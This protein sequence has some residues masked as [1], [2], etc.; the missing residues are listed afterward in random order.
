[1]AALRP[2]PSRGALGLHDPRLTFDPDRER[3]L[4]YL[5]EFVPSDADQARARVQIMRW[6]LAKQHPFE[7]RQ[8]DGHVTASALVIDAAGERALLTHHA[9]LDRWLQFGGHADGDAN[10]AGVALRESIEESGIDDLVIEPRV[11]DVDVHTIPAR[12]DEA[13][14]LHLDVRFLVW[15]PEG[16]KPV[17]S[18]ES[19]ALAWVAADA[20]GG[21]ALDPSVVRLFELARSR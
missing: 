16:A 5:R 10:L 13:E 14:H 15:A 11:V 12:G 18:E 2:R 17:K 7:R 19:H 1:M 9:K 8:T 6:I 21:Y 4:G 20:Q 3:A